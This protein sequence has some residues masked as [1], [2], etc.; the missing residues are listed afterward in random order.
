MSATESAVIDAAKR[1]LAAKEDALAADVAHE[2]PHETE[3][4]LDQAEYDL[5][6]AMYRLL[7][8]EPNIPRD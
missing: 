1:W 6:Q 5:T 8:R 2:D 3:R 7:G 4:A